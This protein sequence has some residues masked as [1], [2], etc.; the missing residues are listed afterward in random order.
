MSNIWNTGT[1]FENFIQNLFCFPEMKAT[2]M[3]N[4]R[5]TMIWRKLLARYVSVIC[6]S[7][8]ALI[9]NKRGV[10][11]S[12]LN[13]TI[14]DHALTSP[15]GRGLVISFYL[16]CPLCNSYVWPVNC[17][18]NTYRYV[19]EKFEAKYSSYPN[20]FI[21]PLLVFC[22]PFDR[23]IRMEDGRVFPNENVFDFERPNLWS[24]QPTRFFC[25]YQ[26][27]IID[28][29]CVVLW[30]LIHW[31]RIQALWLI[32]IQ[33]F[34]EQEFTNFTVGKN[35]KFFDQ[36]WNICIYSEVFMKDF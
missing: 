33:V 8:S 18:L 34:D 10:I 31:I 14:S 2:W 22:V 36:K 12:K 17:S 24:S 26:S 28:A 7:L 23:V 29:Y 27:Q 9:N 21:K 5:L 20:I 32:Q 16:S 15:H 25:D 13:N 30:I 11:K 3:T 1:H 6:D 35:K 19:K 4:L